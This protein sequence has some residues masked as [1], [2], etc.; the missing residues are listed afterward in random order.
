MS[1]QGGFQR[2]GVACGCGFRGGA[3]AGFVQ[4]VL[5]KPVNAHNIW[6]TGLALDA[7]E[8]G[9]PQKP[10]PE[11]A[12]RIGYELRGLEHLR[13]VL[14]HQLPQPRQCHAIGRQ[15]R[16][17]FERAA[18]GG[19][20]FQQH[21]PQHGAQ[22]AFMVVPA[23]NHVLITGDVFQV[24]QSQSISKR[25]IA[26]ARM[27]GQPRSYQFHCQR[28]A[29][30]PFHDAPGGGAFSFIGKGA[31][32][33]QQVQGVGLGQ[34]AQG[35]PVAARRREQ[36]RGG[37]QVELRPQRGEAVGLLRADE[38]GVGNVVE[39]E[40]DVAFVGKARIQAAGHG[41]KVGFRRLA[42]LV[43]DVR[44]D[45]IKIAKAEHGL[46]QALLAFTWNQEPSA[47]I[48]AG[49]SVRVGEGQ[50]G[51]AN[52]TQSMHATDHAGLVVLEPLAEFE[53]F[54][55]AAGEFLVVGRHGGFAAGCGSDELR[56]VIQVPG[57]CAEHAVQII[58]PERVETFVCEGFGEVGKKLAA[59]DLFDDRSGGSKETVVG[60]GQMA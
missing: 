39:H 9:Q 13:E 7:A 1:H 59:A 16:G 47:G 56:M 52:A 32:L 27:C 44:M 24:L 57:Q 49:K 55:E 4:E 58:A 25:P 34:F 38:G 54:V 46:P 18:F 11:L 8:Q 48:R 35:Q 15:E 12:P 28:K 6:F 29:A 53:Q 5:Q 10:L 14:P 50:F 36:P 40:Q 20:Q 60:R 33:L 37:Q 30:Q 45:L 51:L 3:P 19:F 26:R 41:G 31:M 21:R 43:S 17:V 23:Q 2:I 42:L 22:P